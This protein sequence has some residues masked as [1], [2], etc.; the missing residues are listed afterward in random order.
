MR[1]IAATDSHYEYIKEHDHHIL[2]NLIF[3]L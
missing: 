3:W 1:T 2:E